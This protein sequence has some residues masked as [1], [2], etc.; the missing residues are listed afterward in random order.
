MWPNITV[1]HFC[2][3]LPELAHLEPTLKERVLIEG[4][5]ID[6]SSIYIN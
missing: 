1:D 2:E 3:A 6:R 5:L 4:G